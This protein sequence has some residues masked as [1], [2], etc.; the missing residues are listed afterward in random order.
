MPSEASVRGLVGTSDEPI[1]CRSYL[2]ASPEDA[3][4]LNL[5]FRDYLCEGN[6]G[7]N[8]H[9]HLSVIL[10]AVSEK[11]LGQ[12]YLESTQLTEKGPHF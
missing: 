1:T 7:T 2:D 3:K 9:G 4:E 11:V 12:V 5:M 10:H 6:Q 8:L